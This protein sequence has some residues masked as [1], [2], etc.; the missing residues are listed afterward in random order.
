[1]GEITVRRSPDL[2]ASAAGG[3]DAPGAPQVFRREGEY[4]TIVYAGTTV[5]LRDAIGLHY[6]AYLLAHPRQRFAAA[7][8]AAAVKGISAGDAERARS[9]VS[10]RI[11]NAVRRIQAH[12]PTL[13]YHLA[14]GIK[15]GAQCVYVPDAEREST[16]N[17]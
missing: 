12:H 9:A 10:K 15:T 8:L 1:M 2:A 4:W 17:G 3:A 16:W 6:V 14:A 13:G 11:R 7:N 5:R